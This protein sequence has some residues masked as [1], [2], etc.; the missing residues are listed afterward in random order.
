MGPKSLPELRRPRPLRLTRPPL[1]P[2]RLISYAILC[3]ITFAT[4]GLV[5]SQQIAP[6]HRLAYAFLLLTAAVYQ[7]RQLRWNRWV[8]N[9][10]AILVL[11]LS[12]VYG[13]WFAEYPILAAIYFI[14]YIILLRAFELSTTRDCKFALLLSLFEISAASLMLISLRYFF[15]LAAWLAAALFSLC[16]ITIYSRA[17]VKKPLPAPARLFG[18]ITSASLFSIA[19]GLLLF[20]F[21]PRIGFSLLSLPMETGRAWSGYSSTI[22]VGEVSKILENRTPVMRVHTDVPNE[23]PGLKWRMRAMDYYESNSW[24]DRLGMAD[25]FPLTYNLPA[26]VDLDPPQGLKLTQEFYLEPGIGPELPAAAVAY[27]Y[28][29]PY[30]YRSLTCYF[31]HYCS[32]P[33]IPY[34]RI[35]YLAYSS[36]PEYSPSQVNQALSSV[37]SFLASDKN[38]WAK[39]LLQLPANSENL[40]RLAEELAGKEPDPARKIKAV[41]DFFEQNFKY[42]VSGLP[43]GKNAIDEFLFQSR[44]GDCEYF[45]TAGALLLRCL[46]IPNRLAAGFISGEWNSSQQYYLVRESDAHT[47]VEIYL[48]G[49]GFMDFD[50]TPTAGRN[51]SSRSSL[52]LRLLDPLSFRWNRWIVEFTVQD[53]VRGLRRLEAESVRL[54]YRT[55]FHGPSLRFWLRRN[56]LPAAGLIAAIAGLVLLWFFFW[57]RRSRRKTL[58]RGLSLEVKQAARLYLEMLEVLKQRGSELSDSLTGYE[59]AEKIHLPM[60]RKLV[61]DI[62]GFY[63]R[64][65]YGKATA[66]ARELAEAQEQLKELKKRTTWTWQ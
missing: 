27:A 35:H 42:S 31:N 26:T 45:A 8:F 44:K 65:R 15:L 41:Q 57:E 6:A 20:F 48:P 50:P 59:A 47:W 1:K 3:C 13:I 62:T 39:A 30:K 66:S 16:L 61:R 54:Q 17:P 53:Q 11:V 34:E 24:H 28:Q 37:E 43:T 12:L 49:Q 5:L 36:L 7:V 58:P 22:T 9:I 18:L 64:V 2:E 55:N 25:V 40:C 52:F 51:R 14:G 60:A 56:P 23:I 38:E 63:Y 33:V 4:L 32:L 29:L 46:G 21:L 10:C 19:F